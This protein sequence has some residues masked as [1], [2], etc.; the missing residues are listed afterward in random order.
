[1]VEA[2]SMRLQVDTLREHFVHAQ[3]VGDRREAVRVIIEEGIAGGTSINELQAGVVQAAQVQ[4]GQLWQ[5]QR[6]TIAQ[7][8]M[9]TAISQVALAALFERATSKTRLGKKL[10]ISCPEGEEHELP[11]RLVADF[12]ELEGFDV[13]FLGANVPHDALVHCV[14]REKPDAVGLSLTMAVNV[15][16][17]RT[18]IE[19]IRA[20]TEVPIVVGGRAVIELPGLAASFGIDVDGTTVD[21]LVSTA[22][23]VTRLR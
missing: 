20:V 11:A 21:E 9:A 8:H 19:R 3:L 13:R 22:R 4:I 12:L 23:R 15:D 17:L 14:Q 2:R 18:A 6:V 7:E 1:M 5:Q 10:V 16:S